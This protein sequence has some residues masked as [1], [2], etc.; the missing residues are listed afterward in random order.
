M[1]HLFVP[2][3]SL[4]IFLLSLTNKGKTDSVIEY[5]YPFNSYNRV[6]L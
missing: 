4:T 1:N 6:F 2:L 5:P 3:F